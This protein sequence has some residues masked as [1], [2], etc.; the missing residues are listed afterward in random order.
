MTPDEYKRRFHVTRKQ[1]EESWAQFSTD[2]NTMFGHYMESRKVETLDDLRQLIISDRLKHV[3]PDDARAYVLQN[4]TKE[5]LRPKEVAE[6]AEKFEESTLGQNWKPEKTA[7]RPQV[8]MRGGPLEVGCDQGRVGEL[9][10]PGCFSCGRLG[11]LKQNCPGLAH[12]AVD[13]GNKP[14]SACLDAGAAPLPRSRE[15]LETTG[16]RR[17]GETD[18]GIG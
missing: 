5:W 14:A 13:S 12:R 10:P 11:H 4:E 1:E 18:S 9:R 8:N 16:T 17:R 2:L 7:E 15:T 3:M 6:L